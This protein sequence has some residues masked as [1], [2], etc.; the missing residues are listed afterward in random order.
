MLSRWKRTARAFAVSTIILAALIGGLFVYRILAD[1]AETIERAYRATDDLADALAGQTGT[2][3][4]TLDRTLIGIRDTVA[5]QRRGGE[6][7]DAVLTDRLG[8]I[9]G[10]P[11]IFVL[12]AQGRLTHA[13]DNLTQRGLDMSKAAEFALQKAATTDAL[14][15]GSPLTGEVGAAQGRNVLRLARRITTPDGAFAGVVI[16]DLDVDYLNDFYRVL[17][18]GRG[19]L[20]GMLH[21]NG[22]VLARAPFDPKASG[23]NVR[24][25]PFYPRIAAGDE[26]FRVHAVSRIDD[27][28]R[29]L[30]FRALP[31]RDVVVYVG[32]SEVETLMPWH[33]R[34]T[35]AVIAFLVL[36]LALFGANLLHLRL[37][38][39][40]ERSEREHAERMAL[41]AE[42]GNDLFAIGE[43]GALLKRAN[44]WARRIVPAHWAA[45][46]LRSGDGPDMRDVALSGRYAGRAGAEAPAGGA[47]DRLV[48]DSNRSMRLTQAQAEA[49]PANGGHPPPRGWLAAPLIAKDGRNIGLIQLSDRESGDFTA[50]DEAALVQLAHSVS[51]AIENM[52]HFEAAQRAA[53]HAETAQAQVETILNSISDAFYA[54]DRDWRFTYLNDQACRILRRPRDELLG[55]VVWDEFPE[56]RDTVLYPQYMA[57]REAG[58]QTD[59][60]FYYAPLKLWIEVRVYPFAGGLSVYF[61]DITKEIEITEQLRQ[62]QKMEAVGQLTGGVAHDFNNLLTVILG[63]L[64][65]LAM[66][67]KGEDLRAMAETAR[68]GAERA[69]DLTQRLLAFARRQP[70]DP[71]TVD[72]GAL[73]SRIEGLLRRSLGEHI[74]MQ[75]VA[76]ASLH[77]V[78]IDPGQLENAILNLAINARDAMPD[79][80]KLTIETANVELDSAYVEANPEI[81]PGR[82]VMIAVTDTGTGMAPDVLARAFD[83][84]FTTKEVGKGSGLG[85]SMVYGFLKQSGG[86]AKIYSEVGQGTAVKMY[87][88]LADAAAATDPVGGLSAEAPRGSELIMV[89][90]DDSLVRDY[91]VGLLKGLGYRTAAYANGREAIK[92][93]DGGLRPDMLFSDIVLPGGLNGRQVTDE[94]HKRLPGLR[95]LYTSGYTE[96]AIVHH[97]RLDPGTDL[98]SKPFRRMDLARKIREILDRPLSGAGS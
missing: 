3:L 45:I 84:F 40:H 28:P 10:V 65:V 58:R 1:R 87:V 22:A 11:A 54:L 23:R 52:Q 81:H 49:H 5:Q 34:A 73:L 93:I 51:A 26:R 61:H 15:I 18:V 79:G 33:Q 77:Q 9:A 60:Q 53:L 24:D 66:E 42:A 50:E 70:L 32:V 88:P 46:G 39:G 97:G 21:K 8:L 27:I 85:L 20:V 25:Q 57:A 36:V 44:G 59:F 69:A 80:G 91:A 37:L 62:A 76:G 4:N 96:N 2:I 12:D 67:V 47:M 83:P 75:F 89:V 38:R 90:E 17:H 71:K 72:V 68:M 6:N 94:V 30:S 48:T 55:R 74:E 16:A 31:A 98:V 7:I 78:R 29:L 43:I 56:A 41:L 13:S 19:G 82:Y 64:D 63:N 35:A 92:A 86:H 95:V 14:L